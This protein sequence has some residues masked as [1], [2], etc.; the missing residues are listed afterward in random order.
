MQKQNF[1]VYNND[2]LV[3]KQNFLVYNNDVFGLPYYIIYY[4]QR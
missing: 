2:V 4:P 3:Q 1:L